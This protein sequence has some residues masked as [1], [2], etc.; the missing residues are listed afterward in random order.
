MT[1][2]NFRQTTDLTQKDYL[3]YQHQVM[4]EHLLHDR[5][6]NNALLRRLVDLARA[7]ASPDA[8]SRLNR[9]ALSYQP[10]RDL[11]SQWVDE[12]GAPLA[13][14]AAEGAV[15]L[16]DNYACFGR[17]CGSLDLCFTTCS[18]GPSRLPSGE[19]PPG[20]QEGSAPLRHPKG[21]R[22]TED[23]LPGV[24]NQTPTAEGEVRLRSDA[25]PLLSMFCHV[26][27]IPPAPTADLLDSLYDQVGPTLEHV[28]ERLAREAGQPAAPAAPEVA[29]PPPAAAPPASPPQV[30]QA[31]PALQQAPPT[32]PAP[33]A[34]MA[35]PQAAPPTPPAPPAPQQ[36]LAPASA[37]PTPPAPPQPPQVE[38]A[39]VAPEED[40]KQD[41]D[42]LF[43]DTTLE[44]ELELQALVQAIKTCI[45]RTGAKNTLPGMI[46][47]NRE[48]GY[49]VLR[50]ALFKAA[51]QKDL[52]TGPSLKADRLKREH[53]PENIEIPQG[54]Y[55]AAGGVPQETSS[56]LPEYAAPP[57]EPPTEPVRL[58]PK[59]EADKG[60]VPEVAQPEPEEQEAPQPQQGVPPQPGKAEQ[61]EQNDLLVFVGALVRSLD[62]FTAAYRERTA[63]LTA[64]AKG[65]ALSGE[66]FSVDVGDIPRANESAKKK[67]AETGA[68]MSAQA[69]VDHREGAPAPRKRGR[70]AKLKPDATEKPP[71]QKPKKAPA[72]GGD[73]HP[74]HPSVQAEPLGWQPGKRGRPPKGVT[75]LKNGTYKFPK[76]YLEIDGLWHAPLK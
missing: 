12:N 9:H 52:T 71:K 58:V 75:R 23:S 47:R 7:N 56:A 57:Q 63:V 67:S 21:Y 73:A 45:T 6:P 51:A 55:E 53:W 70:P 30:P 69:D 5:L 26:L 35:P 10:L 3:A 72:A 43:A 31:A 17:Q 66:W 36:P 13:A 20:A 37:P 11:I 74:K 24:L 50:S 4:S 1:V 44:Q 18:L 34:P 46:S 39:S 61:P 68:A 76:G 42:S 40:A 14:N 54:Y 8:M 38:T 25:C 19:L 29:P 49:K 27:A 33:P 59:A 48:K 15:G 62:E 60:K 41:D 2:E 28:E 16:L 64:A 32:P 22:L 65:K